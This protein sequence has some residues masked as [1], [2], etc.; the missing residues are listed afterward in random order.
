MAVELRADRFYEE[1]DGID[2]PEILSDEDARYTEALPARSKER[3]SKYLARRHIERYM[4]RKALRG[5]LDDFEQFD[6]D[7]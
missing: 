1:G 3:G 2:V 6:P 4:E 7:F 5:H